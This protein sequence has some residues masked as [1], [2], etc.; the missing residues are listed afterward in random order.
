MSR[1]VADIGPSYFQG[2]HPTI[3]FSVVLVVSSSPA[4]NTKN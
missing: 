4:D 3:N 2:I 1:L